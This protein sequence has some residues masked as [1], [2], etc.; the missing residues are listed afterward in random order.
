MAKLAGFSN[1]GGTGEA[2]ESTWDLAVRGETRTKERP[3]A[4]GGGGGGG[5]EREEREERDDQRRESSR[6]ARDV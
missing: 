2:E 6:A 5:R 4:A 3:C 1:E